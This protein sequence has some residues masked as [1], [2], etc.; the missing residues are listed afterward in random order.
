MLCT[1][2]FILQLIITF[3]YVEKRYAHSIEGLIFK[4]SFLGLLK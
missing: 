1:H 2:R 4:P 3:T